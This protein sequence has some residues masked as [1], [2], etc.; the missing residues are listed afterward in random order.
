MGLTGRCRRARASYPFRSWRPCA[1]RT[2]ALGVAGGP[3]RQGSGRSAA[4]RGRS[5]ARRRTGGRLGVGRLASSRS[6]SLMRSKSS[7]ASQARV[8]F[9]SVMEWS[10]GGSCHR[11]RL[12]PRRGGAPVQ[13]ARE[14]GEHHLARGVPR[15]PSTARS[16][17]P[18]PTARR[19]SASPSARS[20]GVTSSARSR[21]RAYLFARDRSKRLPNLVKMLRR[22][23]GRAGLVAGHEIRCRSP[24]C[25]WSEERG[26]RRRPGPGRLPALPREALYR[27]PRKVRF[28]DLRHS[29][30]TA[31]VAAGGKGAGQALLAHSD[32]RMTLE[33]Y[34]PR[35]GPPRRRGDEGV[36]GGVLHPC[37]KTAGEGTPGARKPLSPRE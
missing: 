14:D 6:T 17:P 28:H 36:R 5:L 3:R 12:R 25:G 1:G 15:R 21:R 32:P 24:R 16:P 33:V 30:G 9:A 4:W 2:R 22:A 7:Q 37:C 27:R 34:A 10:A 18:S 13:A 23:C 35:R 11:L 8:R 26:G 19:S 20:Y 29:F 31:V